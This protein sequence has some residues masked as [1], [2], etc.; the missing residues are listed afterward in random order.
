MPA[1]EEDPVKFEQERQARRHFAKGLVP[2]FEKAELVVQLTTLY[3]EEEEAVKAA[4]ACDSLEKAEAF[5]TPECELCTNTVRLRDVS[6]DSL[7]CLLKR[8]H[9]KNP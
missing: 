1:S 8:A 6:D 9:D 5:L 7:L 3:Y 2:T 4:L